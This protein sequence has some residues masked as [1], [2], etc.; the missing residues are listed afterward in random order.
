MGCSQS[1]DAKEV[2]SERPI[3][4]DRDSKRFESPIVVDSD[5]QPAKSPILKDADNV[6]CIVPH[7]GFVVQTRRVGTNVTF[8]VNIVHHEQ[9]KSVLGL[10]IKRSV[11][12][13]ENCSAYSVVLPSTLYR[14]VSKHDTPEIKQV[15]SIA[16]KCMYLIVP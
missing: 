13:G 12:D 2:D 4:L 9:A 11:V 1:K 15:C 5:S 8:Y 14:H 6:Q 16:S 3:Q 7:E 10:N